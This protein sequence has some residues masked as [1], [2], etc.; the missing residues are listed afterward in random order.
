[1]PT[2]STTLA[3]VVF[4]H[5]TAPWSQETL[6]WTELA[7][8]FI[9]EHDGR[10][11]HVPSHPHLFVLFAEAAPAPEDVIGWILPKLKNMKDIAIFTDERYET[12]GKNDAEILVEI[13]E[14]V[15]PHFG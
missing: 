4:K 10:F 15:K 13:P 12:K 3:L 1:M 5:L 8:E 9:H 14:M 6:T 7:F 11:H 2:Q